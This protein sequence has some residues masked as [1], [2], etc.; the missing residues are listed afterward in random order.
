MA[1][2]VETDA[3]V[4]DA[5]IPDG[6]TVYRR[7]QKLEPQTPP[8]NTLY[9]HNRKQWRPTRMA[10]ELRR[11]EYGLSIYL[12]LKLASIDKTPADVANEQ[13]PEKYAVAGIGA[14]E[15]RTA[16]ASRELPEHR[17]G[18]SHAA[19]VDPPP[20]PCDPAH[21]LICGFGDLP[22]KASVKNVC[23][24]LAERATLLEQ[25][26]PPPEDACLG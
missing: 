8:V 2:E 17:L 10:F 24:E 12:G 19:R 5:G 16:P 6:E 18:L 25:W 11:G 15:V 14:L 13:D 23:R 22:T 20:R 4:D 9:D 26:D 21:G 1:T 3:P 7:V